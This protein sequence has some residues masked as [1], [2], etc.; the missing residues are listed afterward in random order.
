MFKYNIF[1]LFIFL[2][3]ITLLNSCSKLIEVDPPIDT[4][5]T[6]EVF[7][8]SRQAEWAVASIYSKMVNGTIPTS[9]D[10]EV[11]SWFSTGLSTI[12]GGLSADELVNLVNLDANQ[13][14]Q[15]SR[16]NKLSVRAPGRTTKL[17]TSCYK[18]IYDACAVLEGLEASTSSSLTDSVRKQLT[19]EVLAL[20][21]FSYFYLVN[22]FGDIPLVLTTDF[23][24]TVA[25]PR[26][27]TARIYQQIREDLLKAGSLL[28]ADFAHA[29]NEKVRVN[30]WFTEALLSRVYLYTGEFQKAISSASAVIE[31]SALFGI[32]NNLS[33]VFKKNSREAVLQLKQ[34]SDPPKNNSF[35]PEGNWF[36]KPA[37]FRPNYFISDE[38]MNSFEL[39]D[40]RRGEWTTLNDTGYVPAKYRNI[41]GQDYYMVIRLAELYLIRA[42]ATVLLNPANVNDAIADVNILRK[43]A[44]VGE[45]QN[46]LPANMV[47]E[48]IAHERRVELFL[49]WGHRWFDLKRTGKA[50]DVLSAISY[51]Q[52]WWGNYQFLYPIPENEIK[53]NGQL[54]QNPGYTSF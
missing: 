14:D 38:L 13:E 3:V 36:Y 49:E 42:E 5:T 27:S 53:L 8:N 47:I 18:I 26:S 51:K 22:Y 37:P 25:I 11:L 40:K 41:P 46:D 9:W 43:R 17:W 30:K 34:N 2:S 54:V 33:D 4:M 52:P 28:R 7:S 48:A 19:G 35:T 44:D 31:Q 15:F 6:R 1:R 39:N 50:H 29:D 24:Q 20:R 23:N 16:Q 45:L 10:G 32:E 21:A 12:Q